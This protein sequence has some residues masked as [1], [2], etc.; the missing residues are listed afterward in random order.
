[1]AYDAARGR[2]VVFGGIGSMSHRGHGE[3]DGV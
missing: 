1:M 3:L 2:V